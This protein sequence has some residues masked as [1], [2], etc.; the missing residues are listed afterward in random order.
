MSSRKMEFF[1]IWLPLIGGG[2]FAAIAIGAWFAENKVTGIWFGFAGSVCLLLLFALQLHEH[3]VSERPD[4]PAQPTAIDFARSRAY[5]APNE[6]FVEQRGSAFDIRIVPVNSGQT[7]GYEFHTFLGVNLVDE[8]REP[9]AVKKM[10]T[11]VDDYMK[12]GRFGTKGTISPGQKIL[13]SASIDPAQHPLVTPD[14]AKQFPAVLE[15]G[16]WTV[17]VYGMIS[18]VTFKELQFDRYVWR[19]MKYSHGWTLAPADQSDCDS[20]DKK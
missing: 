1:N 16:P 20:P 12:A 6:V 14:L 13:L 11:I 15:K 3:V 17:F 7:P 19:I 2:L 8:S 9:D 10:C 18:Y 4:Q 5:I